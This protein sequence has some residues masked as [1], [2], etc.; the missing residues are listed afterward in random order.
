M[1]TTWQDKIKSSL[2]DIAT[3]NV[4]T[5]TGDIILTTGSADINTN[6][7]DLAKKVTEKIKIANIEVVACTHS[8]W[9]CDNFTHVKKNLTDAE[10][11]LVETHNETVKSAHELRRE[12]VRVLKDFI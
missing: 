11:L 3:L 5:T 10:K 9:D 4:V 1:T 12:A 2:E 7:E 6:W 8:E